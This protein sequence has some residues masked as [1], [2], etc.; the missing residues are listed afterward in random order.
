MEEDLVID[1]DPSHPSWDYGL[2]A[3]NEPIDIEPPE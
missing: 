3:V 1:G 2:T